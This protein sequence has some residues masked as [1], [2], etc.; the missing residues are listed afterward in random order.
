MHAS[1]N[2]IFCALFINVVH[3]FF[4]KSNWPVNTYAWTENRNDKFVE[5]ACTIKVTWAILPEVVGVQWG[6][7]AEVRFIKEARCAESRNE[8]IGEDGSFVVASSRAKLRGGPRGVDPRRRRRCRH[9]AA[10]A[11]R[12]WNYFTEKSAGA[13]YHWSQPWRFVAS[14]IRVGASRAYS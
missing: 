13:P 3:S 4:L 9:R 14:S 7:E 12:W 5:K 11:A 6:I 10:A 2:V 8:C 1:Y